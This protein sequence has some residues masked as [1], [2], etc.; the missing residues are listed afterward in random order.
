MTSLESNDSFLPDFSF[1]DK[2]RDFPSSNKSSEQ[3]PSNL[4]DA[5]KKVK[6]CM[7]KIN[8]YKD[9]CENKRI[10]EVQSII[11]NYSFKYKII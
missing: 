11:N 8:K 10:I 2:I 3:L 6:G 5:M 1:C 7:D 4:T 9:Y